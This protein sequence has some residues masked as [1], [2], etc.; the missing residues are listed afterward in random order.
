MPAIDCRVRS[1]PPPPALVFAVRGQQIE[2]V[3]C[4]LRANARV[5]DTDER[6]RTACHASARLAYASVLALLLARRPNLA[7]VDSYGKTAIDVALLHCGIGGGRCVLMLLDAVASLER[8]DRSRLCS[9]AATSTAAIQ[10][11][12]DRGIVI[13]ELRCSFG[14]TALHEASRCS[15]DA[16][17]F[18]MLV[19][20]CGI[21]LEKRNY[22]GSSCIHDAVESSNGPALRWLIDAGAD[23]N[24]ANVDG[25]APLHL[26]SDYNCTVALLAAG[27]DVCARELG[28]SLAIHVAAHGNDGAS[29]V[30]ALL[31]AGADL[32]AADDDG[33][34]AREELDRDG[35]SVDADSVAA[36]RRDIARARVDFVRDRALQVCIGLQSLE[37]DALQ[38]CEILLFACGRVAQAVPFHIWWKIATTA[39]HFDKRRQER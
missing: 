35:V 29:V 9:F 19:D 12:I 8:V 11:L 17:V 6:G 4:L 25:T 10:A 39:K 16:A 18:D 23:V 5:D 21:D 31:A 14:R 36:A 2:I 22:S 1:A 28:G 20:V 27:A 32:D 37:L 34:T 26:V 30:P 7:L 24:S 33:N 38:M 3:E 13:S 15:G